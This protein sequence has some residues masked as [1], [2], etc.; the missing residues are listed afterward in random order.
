[1]TLMLKRADLWDI[2]S[3]TTQPSATN[4]AE[5]MAKDLQAQAELM[6][7]L[8]DPQVQ[9]VR[10]CNTSAEIWAFLRSVYHHEDL[11]TQV[12]SLKRLLTASLSENQ[13]IIKFLDEWRTLLDNALLSGLQLDSNLQ[14]MLLLAALPSSWRPF[15]TTQ[16]SVA[17]LTVESLMARIRQEELMRNGAHNASGMTP[18]PSIQYVQRQPSFRRGPPFRKNTNARPTTT[19]T[20]VCTYCGRNGHL[21]RE[22]RTKRREQHHQPQPRQQ[23]HGRLP[24]A[25]VQ[26]LED[27]ELGQYGI[28][29]LQLFTSSLNIG[30]CVPSNRDTT[31]WLLDTGATHHMTP[32]KRWLRDYKEL[33]SGMRVYL[34]NNQSL[35]AIGVGDLHVTLPSGANVTIYNVY[36]IPGLS[37]NILSVTTATMSGSSIEFFHDSCIIHFKLPN[38]E[39]EIIKL[40]QRDRLYPIVICMSNPHYVI[41]VASTHSLHL[42][43]A[44][45]TLMW[46]YRFGH[47]NNAT[48][49]RMIKQ[50]LCTGL[51][52]Y[53]NPIELCEGCI[54]GKSS[55]KSHPKSQAKSAQLN[56]LVH[57]DLCGPM[58]TSSLTG[59]HYFLTF[60]DDFS[61]YTTIYFLKKK[62]E[63]LTYFKQYCNLVIR[64][65]D[66][67]IQVLRSDNGGEYGSNAF[68]AFCKDEGIQ[69][70]FTVPYTPQQNGVSER[71]NRTLVEAARAMLLTAGLPKSYWEEAVATACYVQ[72]RVPHATEPNATPYF[73]W[74]GKS[75]NVQHLRIFGCTAYP[76]KALDLRK[77]LDATSSRMIFVG[78]GD[79]FGVKAYRLY[80]PTQR[81]FHL[82]HSVYFDE[83][84][85]ISPQHETHTPDTTFSPS[86]NPSPSEPISPNTSPPQTNPQVEWEETTTQIISTLP[87][88]STPIHTSLTP[89][90]PLDQT[91]NPS[92]PSAPPWSLGNKTTSHLFPDSPNSNEAPII[93]IDQPSLLGPIPKSYPPKASKLRS[94]KDIY[95]KTKPTSSVTQNPNHQ[96]LDVIT[97]DP[98]E[99]F[100]HHMS[101]IETP[102]HDLYLFNHESFD[103]L[104]IQEALSGSEATSWREAMDAEYQSLMENG[105]W[106]LVPP[107]TDRKLVTCKW[108][109]R[110]KFHADGTISRYKARLVARGFSQVRGMD[111]NETFSPVLRI[112]SFRALLATAAQFRLII[113]QMDV[114]TAFLHGNLHEEIYMEQPPG[115]ISNDHPNYV[116]KLVK[117]LYGLKQSPRQWYERFTNCMSHLGYTR[118]QSDPNVY[119]RHGPNVILIL[120]IYVDDIIIL[121]NSEHA[122]SKAKSEL[123]ASFSMQDM[124][125]LHYCLGIQVLQDPSHA[126]IRINQRPYIES[127]LQKYNMSSCKGVST[128]LPLSLK[129]KTPPS[130]SAI[131]PTSDMV[132]FPYANILG[133]IRY[134]VTC[135]RPDICFA[136]NYLSRY[137]QAPSP[138]H[139][140]HLKRLLRYLQETKDFGI[141]Y[142]ACQ[143]MPKPYLTCYSDAD[144]GGDQETLQSTS[145]YIYLLSCGAI[146][147]QSKKQERVTLSSTEA[148]YVAMTL[149]LKEGLWLKHFLKETTLFP[150][151]PLLLRCDNMSTIM[152]AKNLKHSELTKHIAMK[153]Q[154]TRELLHEGNIEITHVRTDQQW[155]DFLTKSTQK[156]KHYESCNEIGL[157]PT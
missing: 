118:F 17:N 129:T 138:I 111:Y 151:H 120:A 5:W 105:T 69:Q 76:V 63:V 47:I 146:S 119:S 30:N 133:G 91:N 135:T 122:L 114:R 109:L 93:S 121:C 115:Y 21:E 132:A 7:H 87:N 41:G 6:F 101:Q 153:L 136:A 108:L 103:D 148:E 12:A 144:W 84:S 81:R 145:G 36:H 73:H 9:M 59:S 48:L 137:M 123:Q 2:V 70:Q 89:T 43:K 53:L 155:A 139:T 67:P 61:R 117:S 98:L 23:Q 31:E 39:F 126:I 33:S 22:C 78:Y 66:L 100:Y 32:Q 44:V 152:L 52:L 49:H 83:T 80:D 113:H 40:P 60:I 4:T 46:H 127:L 24:R 75:P 96:S 157:K 130:S 85:L 74:F 27:H 143:P 107:P 8:G 156:S 140:Q 62:S 25:H 55:H 72:N 57:S 14:A 97:F 102:N 13:E 64:Q 110:K 15:I 106:Y 18:T 77:K 42:T 134:L 90:P 104:T 28:D 51:P 37:R 116:C 128:P 20:K 56:Q 82:A 150:D 86:I 16:A 45:S 124:G 95:E 54:L 68:E 50:K 112:T 88:I 58:E 29:T 3:G 154:F 35:M 131:T 10:R 1:M 99:T 141:T 149:A 34:G 142:S 94:L 71:K 11:I 26:Q 19:P 147:W 38:G 65:H 92:P 125:A 79:R